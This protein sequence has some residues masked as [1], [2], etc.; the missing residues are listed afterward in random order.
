MI[1]NIYGMLSSLLLVKKVTTCWC[2]P[3]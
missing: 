3:V 2:Y 1:D